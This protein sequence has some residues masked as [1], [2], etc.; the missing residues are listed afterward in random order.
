MRE[1]R[2]NGLA[3]LNIHSKLI[4]PP[5]EVVYKIKTLPKNIQSVFNYLP[6]GMILFYRTIILITTKYSFDDTNHLLSTNV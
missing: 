5:V 6:F 2:L 4:L 3:S 1:K